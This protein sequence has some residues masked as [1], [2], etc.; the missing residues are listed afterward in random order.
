MD[1]RL[2]FQA[3]A[4]ASARLVFG[5]D[6]SAPAT[7]DAIISVDADLPGLGGLLLRNGARALL[8]ASLP[9]L[10]ALLVRT[11]GVTALDAPLPGL[12]SDVGMAWSANV[13]RGGAREPM[14]TAWQVAA[15]VAVAT[16]SAW[17]RAQNLRIAAA[18]AWQEGSAVQAP[19]RAHWE[20]ATRLRRAAG[21]GW[22][23]AVGVRHAAMERWQEAIRLRAAVGA[24]WQDGAGL[25]HSVDAGW[26]DT[27]RLRH[28]SRAQ[29]QQRGIVVR[30]SI[31]PA[32]G[33]GTPVAVN[34]W[35][36][37]QDAM[38]PRSGVTPAVPPGPP[39]P[40]PCYAPD[41]RIIF[42]DPWLGDGRL[43][44]DCRR[45][46]PPAPGVAVVPIRRVYIVLNSITLHRLDN[47]AELQAHGF[48]M[49][50]DYGSWTWQWSASLHHSASAH[51]GRDSAGDPPVVVAV[52]NGQA[53]R[54]RLE[55][56]S[57][58]RRFNPTRWAVSG[59]GLAAT[60]SAPWAA[61]QG[62]G[63]VLERTGRQLA[64]EVLTVNSAPLG[65]ALDWQLPEWLVPAG[66][67]T[68]QGSYMDALIDIAAS[69]GGYV[70]PHN[71][72]DTLRFLPLYPHAPWDWSTLLTPD[73]EIPAAAG[74]VE[75][76]EYIDKPGYNKIWIGGAGAQGVF[77]P[78]VRVGTAGDITAPQ[79]NHALITDG[80]AH[81]ARGLAELS[82]TG[83]QEHV[84]LTMQVLPE[85]GVI[86]PGKVVKYLG[87]DKDYLG[88]VRSTSINW[89]R[90]KLRQTIL[91]ETHT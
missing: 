37:W 81:R 25:R 62:F 9:G 13:S 5:D 55:R 73:F 59:R 91:I 58:D 15:P 42:R 89:S 38:R 10:G 39:K 78:A 83:A 90:P 45:V 56:I 77:G 26:Q 34:L 36:A 52:V 88:I 35:A 1:G 70:Q 49:S 53:F 2:V 63:N 72:A 32:W 4:S 40:V 74:E 20:E 6:G 14:G 23:D 7:P 86:V 47:G 24:R 41:G 33:R 76:T 87:H 22:Q 82:N 80:T 27:L 54:L 60:L 17:Q 43:I 11:G 51:L 18:A 44:F 79:I 16:E 64:E 57:R 28:A 75:G 61:N 30:A 3:P 21:A 85:T 46:V 19:A 71:T 29:W 48:S 68:M 84:T 8:D 66:V 65:W 50:L 12:S 31:T 67:W 69:V